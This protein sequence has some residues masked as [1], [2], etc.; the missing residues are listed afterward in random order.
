MKILK[1]LLHLI[2]IYDF[3]FVDVSMYYEIRLSTNDKYSENKGEALND[4]AYTCVPLMNQC[5]AFIECNSQIF[6][7]AKEY[8]GFF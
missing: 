4:L 8:G 6:L 2:N 7:K 1:K 3:S 5:M